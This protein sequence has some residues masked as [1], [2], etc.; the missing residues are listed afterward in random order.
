MIYFD[1]AATTKPSDAAVKA[2]LDALCVSWGN[3]SSRHGAGREAKKA[4]D[5][6]K[7]KILNTIGAKNAPSLSSLIFT[8][9]G[10][11]ATN[12]AVLG[13]CRAKAR[14]GRILVGDGEHASVS[15]AVAQAEREGFEV[16]KI[17]T[18]GGVLDIDAI[19]AAVTKNTV[20]AS[21]MLVNNETGARYD[22]ERAFKAVKM[23][24]PNAICHCDAVQGYL[25]VPFTVK[26]LGADLITLSAHKIHGPKGVGA[27]YVSPDVYKRR[28]LSAVVFGGG[29]EGGYRS[30]TENVP[31]CLGFAAAA[32]E[33]FSMLEKFSAKMREL[34]EYIIGGIEKIDGVRVNKPALA[35]PHI[36]SVTLPKIKSETMLHFLWERGIAVSSGSACST[37]S[38]SLSSALQAFGLP[39]SEAD[40]TI[41]VSLCADNTREDADELIDAIA[42]GVAK[43]ARMR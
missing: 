43:L 39:A 20:L 23:L 32:E 33:E 25:K 27:L 31:A 9:S 24:C 40:T 6:A 2:V 12:L 10:T 22:V 36:V 30:G 1:N 8:G 34:R 35:A 16:V 26:S 21:F 13:V 41:R 42:D 14:R 19:K 17:P 28:E 38:K 15:A 18:V 5:A 37:H 29:Q 4:L 7:T 11:E 3:P